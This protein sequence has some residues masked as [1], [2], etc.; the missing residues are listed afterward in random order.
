MTY[1]HIPDNRGVCSVCDGIYSVKRG[2]SKYHVRL[3]HRPTMIRPHGPKDARCGGSGKPI[4]PWLEASGL[5]SWEEMSDSDKGAALRY[6]WKRKLE[7]GPY[8][9]WNYPCRY[10]DHP[11]LCELDEGTS[12]RH[13]FSV[14]DQVKESLS[15]DEF[16]RLQKINL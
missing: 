5:P 7:G 10:L 14:Y 4:I 13:A 2:I 15:E 11:D 12:C 1:R 3:P 16:D 6:I 8:A 9:R